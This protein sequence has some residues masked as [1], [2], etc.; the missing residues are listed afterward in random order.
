MTGRPGTRLL[1]SVVALA[2]GA[3]AVVIVILLVKSAL[4]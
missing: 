1:A 4:G 2:A 3:T